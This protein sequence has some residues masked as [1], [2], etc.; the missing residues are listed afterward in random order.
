M[1]KTSTFEI[2]HNCEILLQELS[3][4]DS[5]MINGGKS[6]TYFHDS[7]FE[8]KLLEYALVGFAISNIVSLVKLF[9]DTRQHR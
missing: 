9:L 1:N 5:M 6:N 4:V 3:D 2:F 7:N 8:R